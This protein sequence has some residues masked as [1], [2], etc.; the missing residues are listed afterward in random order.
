MRKI[1]LLLIVLLLS[2][3]EFSVKAAECQGHI[4]GQLTNKEGEPVEGAYVFVMDDMSKQNIVAS[5]TSNE[6]GLFTLEA[7]CGNKV[8]GISHIGYKMVHLDV[9]INDNEPVD[10]GAYILED[11]LQELQTV[12]V[13]GNAI[14]VKSKA[15]GFTVD[16]RDIARSSNNALDLLGRL[17]QIR[18]KENNLSVI[19]KENVLLRVNNVL[20]R[21]SS[22]QLADVL[23]GYGADLISSVE[24]VTTPPLKY[25]ADGTTAMIILHMDSKFNKFVGGNVGTEIMK[26]SR[27][28]GRYAVYGSGIFNNEKLFVDITPSCNHNYSYMSEHTKYAYDNG[29]YYITDNPSRGDNDYYGAYATIQYQYSKR[30]YVGLNANVN[31]RKVENNFTSRESFSGQQTFNRNDIDIERPRTNATLYVEQS[32][33][34][35][36]KGWLETSYYNYEETTDQS[37]DGYE[38]EQQPPLMSYMS[39]QQLKVDGVTFSNDYSLRLGKEGN[40]SLDFGIRAH[41]AHISNF[42][43]NELVQSGVSTPQQSDR[44]VVNEIKINPY[45]STTYRP[46]D[47]LNLRLGLQLTSNKRKIDGE[48]IEHDNL[49]YTN[50]LPDFL[51]SWTPNKS[52][53]LSMIMTSG[54]TDPK[55]GHINP[56]I[57]RISQNSYQKGNLGLKSENLYSYRLVYTYRGNLSVTGYVKHKKND[58]ESVGTV[59]DGAVHYVS[60]NAQNTVEYG[61]RPSYYYDRLRWLEFSIDAYGGI[62]VS[63]GLIPEV[64]RKTTSQVWGGNA[65]ASF[66]FNRQRTFTGYVTCD[67]TGRQKTA[68][69]TVDPMVDFGAGLSWF[70]L[71]RKL[72]LSLSGLNLFSSSY[73]GKSTREGYTITFDNKYNYPTLYLSV[74]YQFN[75]VKD[76]SPR[77]QKM[78][79]GI[80]QR[81]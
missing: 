47:R 15:D 17:P 22:D 3:I 49:S 20:Q 26:G 13:R 69:S 35:R 24:V 76:S 38:D 46:T 79:R 1:T 67:Y 2:F 31:K 41:Y 21:V 63:K 74:T 16:V 56:F 39:D 66:I 53:R 77:R 65:F 57:W 64:E 6:H 61:I 30:G 28:N 23:R 36:L 33:T 42:R 71:N 37:F 50:L 29:G 7:P 48:A 43:N 18:V 11:N 14:K 27:Y 62:G 32:L 45:F 60:A 4:K 73:K 75:N 51:A 72:G 58:I 55:F 59:V 12:I 78:V 81:M 10:L 25:D 19:G 8:L 44:I 54:S 70:L 40:A 34:D 9:S 68:V 52:S 5:T 80:E